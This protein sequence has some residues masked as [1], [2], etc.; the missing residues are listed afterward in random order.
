MIL[1]ILILLA[2]I[3]SLIELFLNFWESGAASFA[4]AILFLGVS[5]FGFI[6]FFAINNSITETNIVSLEKQ[7]AIDGSFILG[8]GSVEGKLVYYAYEKTEDGGYSL[9]KIDAEGSPNNKLTIYERNET[10]RYIIEWKCDEEFERI[11]YIKDRNCS[12]ERS[13]IVP[14]NTIIKEFKI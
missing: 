13:L 1:E 14:E 9:L 10:P 12:R 3:V 7:N 4:F 8:G 6:G 5:F 11:N 2:G